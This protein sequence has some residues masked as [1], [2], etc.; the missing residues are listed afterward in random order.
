VSVG[1][2][3][4]AI[5]YGDLFREVQERRIFSDS[6]C[7][8]DAMP[9]RAPATIL[10]AFRELDTPDDAALRAFVLDNFDLPASAMPRIREAYSLSQY[11]EANW[12]ALARA[13][14]APA[15]GS[16]ALALPAPFVVPGGRFRELYY[17]DSYFTML[18]L[19][20]DGHAD[21]VEAMI[22]NFT[23]L[24]ERHG[25]V[26][27]GTRTYYLGRSQ[28]P[29]FY[30]MMQLS[31]CRD[32][33]ILRRRLEAMEREHAFWMRGVEFLDPGDADA[34]CA[35]L[36]DG[37]VVNRYWDAHEHPRE[38]SWAE[39]LATAR[40]A[41]RPAPQVWRDLRAA[42]ESGWD[43]SSRWLGDSGTLSSIRTTSIAPVDLN[44]LL[45]GLER[46]IADLAS[47]LGHRANAAHFDRLA[48]TR[49]RA[50]QRWFWHP[51]QARFAD[52]DLDTLHPTASLNAAALF[53]LFTG[54]VSFRQVAAM[55]RLVREHLLAAG[56]LRTTVIA[57]GE[58]WDAPNGWAPLQWIALAGFERHGHHAL[59]REIANRWKATVEQAYAQTGEIFE[60][61]D[62]EHERLGV[63][64]EYEVQEGFGWTNGVSRMIDRFLSRKHA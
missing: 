12:T 5:V 43:F 21:L 15:P 11:I 17:W 63:G 42:A 14:V 49:A 44:H 56:G 4:L 29:F 8:V 9:K 41:D 64:G 2:G 6:K 25:Y 36:P 30:L 16:T 20:C 31:Q 7:F 13:P 40:Q 26:P 45:F 1:L 32:P 60:K 3:S 62:I 38:E 57:S 51:H 35:R 10:A 48:R 28:P 27:N 52:L 23:V 50:N 54:K 19:A 61:Y 22:D 39:D 34:R 37:S 24:I 58:Q 33:V 53:P 47:T 18:G 46:A 55:A 59:A